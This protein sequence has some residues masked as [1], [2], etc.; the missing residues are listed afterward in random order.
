MQRNHHASDSRRQCSSRV[1][2]TKNDRSKVSER[3]GVLGLLIL[4]LTAFADAATNFL[5][6]GRI[7]TAALVIVLFLSPGMVLF[8]PRPFQND[9]QKQPEVL[10]RQHQHLDQPNEETPLTT[11]L[12]PSGPQPYILMSLGRSGSGSTWQVIGTLTGKETPSEEYTGSSTP[13]SK[14]FF[15]A[16]GNDDKWLVQHLCKKQQKYRNAKVVGFK[17]KPYAPIF[18]APAAQAGLKT[19]STLK[20][21]MIKIVRLRRN[22]LD[23]QISRRKHSSHKTIGAHCMKGDLKCIEK[24]VNAS[25]GLDLYTGNMGRLF[26]RLDTLQKYE[27]RVDELLLKMN[28][29]HVQ[30]KYERLFNVDGKGGDIEEWEKIF[31]FLGTGP[32]TGLTRERLEGGM[33]HAATHPTG[34]NTTLANYDEVAEALKGTKYENLLHRRHRRV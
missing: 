8:D 17:W 31:S 12:D 33:K 4:R 28:V 20:E 23:V 14:Q 22:L 18:N 26:N 16:H 10:L 5:G 6:V 27:D 13:A 15:E 25:M 11:C 32:A 7:I 30:V 29:P 19:I 24:G 21:P 3:R 1:G 2:G 34:H 9:E